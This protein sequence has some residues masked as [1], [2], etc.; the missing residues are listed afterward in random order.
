MW[1]SNVK[2]KDLT[3]FFDPPFFDPD[4]TLAAR[5]VKSGKFYWNSGMFIWKASVILE[6]IHRHLPGLH[7]GLAEIRESFNTPAAT[8]V[9]DRVYRRLP[10]V[11]IDYGVMEK[12]QNVLVIPAEFGWS[13]VGSWDAL[14]DLAPK[15][16]QGNTL[17]GEEILLQ[18]TT[19]SLVYSP[20]KLV[21]LVG[22][23][24]VIVVDT[25]DALLICKRGKSQ[26]V[27]DVV[28]AL[29]AANRKRFL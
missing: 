26:K 11:S 7:D 24:D 2:N 3:P 9:L 21:A 10:S 15:D 17:R 27:K 25:K 4:A 20:K 1:E 16:P 13:D 18:D 8:R 22:M 19:G 5:F 12:A 14:W 23:K 29:E 28:D 6:E